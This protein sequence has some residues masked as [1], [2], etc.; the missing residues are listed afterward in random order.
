MKI[1]LQ[2]GENRPGQRLAIDERLAMRTLQTLQRFV[3]F[4]ILLAFRH[5]CLREQLL[6]SN[7]VSRK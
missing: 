5:H 1:A 7:V 2:F 4:W 3:L 6:V